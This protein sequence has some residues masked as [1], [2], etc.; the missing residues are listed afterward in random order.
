MKI[1]IMGLII[2]SGILIATNTSSEVKYK[3]VNIRLIPKQV[4]TLSVTPPVVII[5]NFTP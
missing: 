5:P 3:T 4:V 2:L 1:P